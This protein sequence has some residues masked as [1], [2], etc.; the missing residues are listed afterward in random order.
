MSNRNLREGTL[1]YDA[2]QNPN[3]PVI[4]T[5]PDKGTVAE[6]DSALQDLI[7]DS[8]GNQAFPLD[9]NTKCIEVQY[10]GLDGSGKTYTMPES[11]IAI[12]NIELGENGLGT[13]EYAAYSIVRALFAEAIR[14][15][16]IPLRRLIGLC[17]SA[18]V[19][20]AVVSAAAAEFS[21][22]LAALVGDS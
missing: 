22:E 11:R 15:E 1:A 10:L 6:Q 13:A 20:E 7:M 9:Y 2:G 16:E 12:P 14:S 19:S 4:I 3:K 21:D 18:G 17:E 5:D 8:P